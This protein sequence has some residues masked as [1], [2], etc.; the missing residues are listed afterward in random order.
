VFVHLTG[1]CD[2]KPIVFSGMHNKIE[3]FVR[4]R[5]KMLGMSL[6]ELSRRA[7]ISRQTL[8]ELGLAPSRLP[9]LTTIVALAEVLEVHPMRLLQLVFDELPLSS[10]VKA[11]DLA[12]RS[13]FLR[14]VNWPDGAPVPAGAHFVK[15]WELQ[16]V[17][18]TAWRDRFL[19]CLDEEVAV[20]TRSGETLRIA[21]SLEPDSLRVPVAETLPGESVQISVGFSAPDVPGTVLSYWKMAYADD[22]LCFPDGRGLWVKLRVITPVKAAQSS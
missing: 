8:Y 16:N 13:A 18:N 9:A 21:R 22:S 1:Q 3:T 19:I 20:F 14:D 17:G 12:D 6:T 10:Q 5:A 15:T 11:G 4:Q 2:A 7:G